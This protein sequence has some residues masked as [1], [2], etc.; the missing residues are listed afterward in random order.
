MLETLQSRRGVG[1]DCHLSC[2]SLKLTSVLVGGFFRVFF[3]FGTC[4][5]GRHLPSEQLLQIFCYS[6]CLAYVLFIAYSLNS[7]LKKELLLSLWAFPL[8]VIP[9]Y[10]LFSNESSS[11]LVR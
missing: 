11:C 3:S 5:P 7:A 8:C 2:V 1:V 9:E 10:G 6:F 4:L